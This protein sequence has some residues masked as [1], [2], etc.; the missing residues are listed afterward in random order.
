MSNSPVAI[1]VTIDPEVIKENNL[2][3]EVLKVLKPIRP[4]WFDGDKALSTLKSKVFTG[5]ISNLLFGYYIEEKFEEDVILLRIYG[6]GTELMIDRHL[7]QKNIQVLHEAGRSPPLYA[8]FNNGIAYGFVN[9]VTLDANT[10]RDKTIARLIA[11]EMINVHAVKPE[12]QEVKSRLWEKMYRFL[13]LGPDK[14]DDSDRQQKFVSTIKPKDVLRQ[15]IDELKSHLEVLNS[16]VVFCHNDLLLKNVIFNEE[17]GQ[18]YFIDHEYAMFNYEHFDIGNHFAEYAGVDDLDFT[19]YPDK[20]YQL[21]WL[22]YYL[23]EKAKFKGNDPASITDKDVEICYVKSNKFALAAHLFWGLWGLVQAKNS[24]IDFGFLE[25][26]QQKLDEYFAR[27][28]EFLSLT[29]PS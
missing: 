18:V 13:D 3:D 19:R 10:V 11:E 17:K 7:E 16:P 29:L 26:A 2:C 1:D 6:N 4:A 9:G 24:L 27:K 28:E 25:Y 22:R 12:G 8:S 5:G 14:F 20:T 23:E 15:E 21:D